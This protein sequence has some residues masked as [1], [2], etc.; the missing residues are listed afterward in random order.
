MWLHR[1]GAKGRCGGSLET[2]DLEVRKTVS[3]WFRI[4]RRRNGRAPPTW[5]PWF[6]RGASSKA[7]V[8]RFGWALA[9]LLTCG[10][11]SMASDNPIDVQTMFEELRGATQI[12]LMLVPY[13]TSFRTRVGEV[14]L[15]E[16]S[17]V[18][19]IVSD[20][21]AFRE[22]LEAF[23]SGVVLSKG[24]KPTLDLRVGIVFKRGS[25]IV[26]AAYFNDFGGL[27]SVDGFVG[28]H[29]ATGSPDLPNLL[30]ALA[31]KPGASL[32]RDRH[33]RCPRP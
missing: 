1:L 22:T 24:T 6:S 25:D 12:V 14:E 32:V 33:S 2:N 13:R 5:Q 30:R 31:V 15:P 10:D 29:A 4:I 7:L 21:P 19:E 20:S 28:E 26:K 9:T 17:C 18:Y 16:V 11:I 8:R 27:R 3:F 23:R